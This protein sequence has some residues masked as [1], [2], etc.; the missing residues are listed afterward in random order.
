MLFH[1]DSGDLEN[2]SKGRFCRLNKYHRIQVI[3]HS[4]KQRGIILAFPGHDSIASQRAA[5]VASGV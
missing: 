5:V 4:N 1:R 2:H 3:K